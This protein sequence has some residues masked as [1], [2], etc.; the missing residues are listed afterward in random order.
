MQ[1]QQGNHL[2][3]SLSNELHKIDNLDITF[4][5]LTWIDNSTML[6]ISYDDALYYALNF[7]KFA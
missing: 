5:R 1:M 3:Y 4:Y 6:F 7:P 2:K